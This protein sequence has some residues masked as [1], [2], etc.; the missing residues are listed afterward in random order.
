VLFGTSSVCRFLA[1]G[2]LFGAGLKAIPVIQ[3]CMRVLGVRVATSSF[4]SP[5]L[6]TFDNRSK[7]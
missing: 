3:V 2:L 7:D 4:D 6:S 1:L 5:I